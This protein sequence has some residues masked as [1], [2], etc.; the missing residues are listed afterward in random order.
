MKIP[1]ILAVIGIIIGVVILY[2]AEPE[3]IEIQKEELI[4]F[5]EIITIGTIHRDY[6]KMSKRYQ[7][8]ADYIAEKLSDETTVYKGIVKIV[9]T[10]KQMVQSINDEEMISF[11]IVH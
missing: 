10:E 1:I 2:P 7:P 8:L 5:D 9:P 3:I 4:E 6:V 11:L